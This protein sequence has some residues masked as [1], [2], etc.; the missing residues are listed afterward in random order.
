MFTSLGLLGSAGLVVG[1]IVVFSILLVIF[2]QWKG[3]RIRD[4]KAENV[5][6]QVNTIT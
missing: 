6:D 3:Q 4:S 2:L 1:L 5:L